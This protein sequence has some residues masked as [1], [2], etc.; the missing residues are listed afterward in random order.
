VIKR[1]GESGGGT[2]VAGAPG[3]VL[4]RR[5]TTVFFDLTVFFVAGRAQAQAPTLH[6][7]LRRRLGK[8]QYRTP[9]LPLRGVLC[10]LCAGFIG[11]CSAVWLRGVMG[12]AVA[13]RGMLG[14]LAAASRD[15]SMGA[16]CG[17]GGSW[18]V[19]SCFFPPVIAANTYPQPASHPIT[20]D[21]RPAYVANRTN[22][23]GKL[24]GT[25][26]LFIRRRLL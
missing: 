4:V 25:L 8:A 20:Y 18:F 24:Q 3:G 2:A 23:R 6:P 5:S 15:A 12:Y 22:R 1:G 14:G 21:Q 17:F 11:G 13:R 19:V 16:L 26:A 9:R 7:Y 10:I